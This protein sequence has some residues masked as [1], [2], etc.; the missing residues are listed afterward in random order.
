[1]EKWKLIFAVRIVTVHIG[2]A[3]PALLKIIVCTPSIALN[4]GKKDPSKMFPCQIWATFSSLA[5][6]ALAFRC[7]DEDNFLGDRAM[8][9]I[10]VNG[11]FEHCVRF[12]RC[13]GAQFQSMSSFLATGCFLPLSTDLKLLSHWM[14]WITL[15]L[16]P[17]NAKLQP[18]VF[19]RS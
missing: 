12:C 17:W 4:S 15:E 16:I 10:H 7:P 14:F 3:R 19:S 6:L 11:I 18:R 13:K 2:G 1:V 5:I 8:T 9:L